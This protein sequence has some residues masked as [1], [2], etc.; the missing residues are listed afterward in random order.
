MW[1]QFDLNLPLTVKVEAKNQT[2]TS[3]ASD[4]EGRADEYYKIKRF[5]HHTTF[6]SWVNNKHYYY[7]CNFISSVLVALKN[8]SLYVLQSG[9]WCVRTA[10]NPC[11][12]K[13][14]LFLCLL[15]SDLFL[16]LGQ[17]LFFCLLT[18]SF[19]R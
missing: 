19:L 4:Y 10:I 13:S 15:N 12:E 6:F 11:F 2:P 3:L 8:W 7:V 9:F 5:S 14:L 17:R 1:N 18:G 16:V